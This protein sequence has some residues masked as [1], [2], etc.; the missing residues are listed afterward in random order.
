MDRAAAGLR[1]GSA[2]GRSDH[3]A[4]AAGAQVASGM[5]ECMSE[6]TS[7]QHLLDPGSS[8]AA[9]D[10]R[11]PKP[12]L[13]MS[14]VDK[15]ES[16]SRKL[17]CLDPSDSTESPTALRGRAAWCWWTRRSSGR[18]WR[19]HAP[20]ASPSSLMRRVTDEI[21]SP[22]TDVSLSICLGCFQTPGYICS[23]I[24]RQIRDANSCV[25]QVFSG[26]WRLG[27]VSAAQLL[28]AQPDI[29]CYAKL[30]TGQRGACTA[31]WSARRTLRSFS[32]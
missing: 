9:P 19:R 5:Q 15:E 29:A 12:A 10:K 17:T 22:R 13:R 24:P 21:M 30:L 14:L 3:G 25:L 7:T 18:S 11:P 16:V 4:R 8:A 6:F 27:A 23:L 20:G 28:G 31:C 32:T 1:C 26:L 2:R